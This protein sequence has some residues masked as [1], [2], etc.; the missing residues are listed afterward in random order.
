MLRLSITVLATALALTACGNDDSG[1]SS[2]PSPSSATSA[3]SATPVSTAPSSSQPADASGSATAEAPPDTSPEAARAAYKEA[4]AQLRRAD[5]GTLRAR[6]SFDDVGTLFDGS[7]R[8]STSAARGYVSA[9][10]GG[11]R[12]AAGSIWVR[13]EGWIRRADDAGDF[14]DDCYTHYST[15]EPPS[16]D[17]SV[18]DLPLGF[19]AALAVLFSGRGVLK[20][21]NQIRVEVDLFRLGL[22]YGSRVPIALGLDHEHQGVGT[23]VVYVED[24]RVTSWKNTTANFLHDVEAAGIELPAELAGDESAS[25]A[26]GDVF[27]ELGESEPVDVETPSGSLVCRS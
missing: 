20:T 26:V 8:L 25:F 16:A 11:V 19:P 3:T 6:A 14:T 27:V 1:P 12:L 24:G 23:I 13:R 7:Y 9:T 10:S 22:V 2:S 18:R 17:A 15:S 21:G 5:S 4:L